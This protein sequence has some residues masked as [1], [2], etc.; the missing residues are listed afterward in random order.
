MVSSYTC[1]NFC[2]VDTIV[3]TLAVVRVTLKPMRADRVIAK[4]DG[5]GKVDLLKIVAN[6]WFPIFNYFY[7]FLFIFYIFWDL[8]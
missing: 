4:V 6:I 3:P 2:Y 8:N 7:K 1:L 5:P